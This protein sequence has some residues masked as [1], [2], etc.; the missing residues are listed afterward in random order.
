VVHGVGRHFLGNPG[1]AD[2]LGDDMLDRKT[3]AS[4]QANAL[5]ASPSPLKIY[6]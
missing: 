6:G 5:T 4:F 3:L 1:L 2:G